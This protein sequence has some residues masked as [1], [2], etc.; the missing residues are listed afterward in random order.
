MASLAVE[1]PLPDPP[2]PV[3]FDFI[4]VKMAPHK[5]IWVRES[6]MSRLPRTRTIY[7]VILGR[8]VVQ[9]LQDVDPGLG[10]RLADEEKWKFLIGLVVCEM[11]VLVQV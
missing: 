10:V 9:G 7:E 3:K 2:V 1:E 8:V 5:G 6:F 4:M 11:A